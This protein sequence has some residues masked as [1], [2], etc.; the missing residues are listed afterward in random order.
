MVDAY[1]LD[2]IT[3]APL[4]RDWFFEQPDGT[5]RLMG[6]FAVGLSETAPIWARSIAP[7]AEWVARELSQGITKPN[8]KIG[9][10][11]H[12][13]QRHRSEAKGVTPLSFIKASPRRKSLCGICGTEIEPDRTHCALCSPPISRT[14][15]AKAARIGR[16]AAQ[17]PKA[18]A[19]RAATKR[20]QDV[21]RAGW[22][23]SSLPAWLNNETYTNTIQPRLAAI[24]CSA[25]ASALK[26]SMPYAA[27]L[28]AGRRRPHP[29]HW[30]ALAQLTNISVR[31]E[32]AR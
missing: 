18:Q 12:L 29:R 23:A 26:V 11:T 7:I 14:N 21:A 28:R 9:P 3:R 32:T 1:L 22:L 15:L 6:S 8:R 13:T 2:W 31:A 30:R 17:S 19:R 25:I 24:T 4:R 20:R 16:I 5:C 10:A 27:A